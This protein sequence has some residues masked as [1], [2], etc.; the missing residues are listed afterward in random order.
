MVVF[1][2][3]LRQVLF[4][5]Q[6]QKAGVE[7]QLRREIEIQAHLR[8]PYILR[9]YGYFYD[10]TR[11]YLILEYAPQGELYKIMQKQPTKYFSELN[12]AKYIKQL[13][14]ALR[15]VTPQDV[16][17]ALALG[18]KLVRSCLSKNCLTQDVLSW[19]V[20]NYMSNVIIVLVLGCFLCANGFIA[21]VLYYVERASLHWY[22]AY[23]SYF[24]LY[25]SLI[26]N[27]VNEPA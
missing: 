22:I 8:H 27:S 26:M 19:C 17:A 1:N 13:S 18:Y 15:W 10:D 23:I 16:W 4:K 25:K 11:V 14:E 21:L 2:A 20:R 3:S 5:S 6:L 24:C 7:H 9:L 12:S